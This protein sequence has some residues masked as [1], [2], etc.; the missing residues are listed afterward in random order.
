MGQLLYLIHVSLALSSLAWWVRSYRFTVGENWVGGQLPSEVTRR[1]TWNKNCAFFLNQ[2]SANIIWK[3][4]WTPEIK[5]TH[6]IMFW[7]ST[8][9]SEDHLFLLREF[10]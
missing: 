9:R 7:G 8:I 4:R 2:Q 3:E 1:I 10:R 6:H 5:V